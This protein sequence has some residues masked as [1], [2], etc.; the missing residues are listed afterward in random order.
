M[1]LLASGSGPVLIAGTP[2]RLQGTVA[3]QNGTDDRLTLKSL[4]IRAP[5]LLDPRRAPLEGVPLFGR[6]GPGESASLDF[7]FA[8]DPAT[9]PGEYSATL[10]VG[11]E[12]H[13]A[14]IRIDD[15]VLL[16]LQPDTVTLFAKQAAEFEC[17]LQLTNRGNV[18]LPLGGGWDA[19]LLPA[20]GTAGLLARALGSLAKSKEPHVALDEVLL[21]AARHC[22]GVAELRWSEATLEAG[23]SRSVKA[24]IKLPAGLAPERH[25]TATLSLYSADLAIDVYTRR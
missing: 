11:G 21:A 12:Q 14:Q 13:K 1:Q 7:E 25:Y 19:P 16:E 8:I 3:V 22:P 6:I 2:G 23:E 24:S 4:S 15:Q 17:H 9:P 10:L 20:G 5:K 18:A